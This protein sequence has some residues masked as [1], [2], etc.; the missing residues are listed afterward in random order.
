VTGAKTLAALALIT[1]L[2]SGAALI[3]VDSSSSQTCT[4]GP[5]GSESCVNGSSTL[6]EENGAWVLA[7]LAVPVVLTL[8]G[9]VAIRLGVRRWLQWL[10]AG[11]FL[12]L[13]IIT[14][15][16]IGTFYLPSALLLLLAVVTNRRPASSHPA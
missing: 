16:T 6:I 7:Y 8:A 4:T 13:C 11:V 2:V 9:L 1:A 15:F 12:F 5:A 3:F 10:I 14:G